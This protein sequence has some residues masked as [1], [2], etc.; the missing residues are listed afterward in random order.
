LWA[1]D[2]QPSGA[3]FQFILPAAQEGL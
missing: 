2:N 1:D 3:V